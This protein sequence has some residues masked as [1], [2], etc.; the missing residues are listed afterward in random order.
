MS[1]LRKCPYC[2]TVYRYK[3][4]IMMKG[5]I[6]ECY[7]CKK[8]FEVIKKYRFIPVMIAC[9]ILVAVNLLVF[10]T[11]GDISKVVF[12]TISIVNAVVLFVSLMTAPLLTWFRALDKKQIKRMKKS[13]QNQ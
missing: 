3:D 7:H 10:T 2:E 6:Q 4:I 13:K 12:L 5:K 9:S 1:T 8:P 11:S